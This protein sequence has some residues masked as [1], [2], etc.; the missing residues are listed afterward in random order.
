MSTLMLTYLLMMLMQIFHI[1]E[2]IGMGAYKVAHSLNKYLFAASVLVTI[3][4]SAFA[5][6]AFNMR[7]G[8]FLGLLTSG[9]LALGNGVVHVFGVIK[10]KTFRDSLGAGVF[11]GIPL[12]IVGLIVFIQLIQNI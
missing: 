6:I 9:V 2:E 1:F 11:T 5:L 3:N 7:F 10:T 4:F 8:L 12:A